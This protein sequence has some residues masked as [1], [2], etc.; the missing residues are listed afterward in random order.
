ML[1][2]LSQPKYFFYF[3]N[4]VLNLIKNFPK[5]FTQIVLLELRI[6]N[7]TNYFKYNISYKC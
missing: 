7:Y 1:S 2:P 6:N 4:L 3:I 5:H